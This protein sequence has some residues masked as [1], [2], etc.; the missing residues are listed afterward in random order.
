MENFLKMLVLA[1]IMT[2]AIFY[3]YLLIKK[4]GKNLLSFTPSIILFVI[5][6]VA[7]AV[8]YINF[9]INPGTWSELIGSAFGILC[10][11]FII[12]FISLVG[13]SNVDK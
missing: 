1:L 13:I 3:S 5:G 2:G 8:L 11:I 6:G 4:T 7:S 9:A 10:I 12:V